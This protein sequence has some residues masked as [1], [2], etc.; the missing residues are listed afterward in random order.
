[1]TVRLDN[2][3]EGVIE[4]AGESLALTLV[5]VVD[6]WLIEI[7]AL[8]GAE[9]RVILR[10]SDRDDD[11]LRP[12]P[13]LQEVHVRSRDD[14][15]AEALFVGQR[16]GRHF[17][18]VAT[19]LDEKI[20]LDVADRWA[21]PLAIGHWGFSFTLESAIRFEPLDQWSGRLL[22]DDAEACLHVSSIDRGSSS[23]ALL[24]LSLDA[25]GLTLL[26]RA[27]AGADPVP[28]QTI[29]YGLSIERRR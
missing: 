9:W 25:D 6:R 15:A 19:V 8:D 21:M 5:R 26:A 20:A 28:P 7:S 24:S 14:G 29:C 10:T 2:E 1:V 23:K 18:A 27:A 17:S 13:T 22:R 4:F 3:R 11:P 12:N 16:S